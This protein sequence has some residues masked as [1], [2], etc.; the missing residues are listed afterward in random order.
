MSVIDVGRRAM[1]SLAAGVEATRATWRGDQWRLEH[2]DPGSDRW[3]A[4]YV[5]LSRYRTCE[6]YV[7]NTIFTK[8]EKQRGVHMME[9]NG[10][11]PKDTRPIYNPAGR[12]SDLYPALIYGGPLDIANLDGGAIPIE[13]ESEAVKGAIRQIWKWSNMQQAKS[14]YVRT[15]ASKGDSFWQVAVDPVKQKVWLETLPPEFVKEVA[16]DEQGNIKRI[17]IAY[18][19]YDAEARKWVAYE[20]WID[21]EWFQTY[22]EGKPYA[23]HTDAGGNAMEK[24]PNI[25]G[26]VP[27]THAKHRDVGRQF[28]VCCF[29]KAIFKIDE[30]TGLASVTH[31]QVRKSVN[32]VWAIFGAKESNDTKDKSM[33]DRKGK[34]PWVYFPEGTDAK[35]MV[36]NLDFASAL[37]VMDAQR[38]EIEADMPELKL[39]SLHDAGQLSGVAIETLMTPAIGLITESMGNYDAPLV[40]AQEMAMTIGGI[41]GIK[42]FP[43]TLNS[44]D[45][46]D[47]QHN[48]KPRSVIRDR[49]SRKEK[50][51]VIMGAGNSPFARLILK[52]VGLTDKEI[53]EAMAGVQTQQQTAVDQTLARIAGVLG[54]QAEDSAGTP[55]ADGQPAGLSEQGQNRPVPGSVALAG[56]A[57]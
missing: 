14:D 11:L 9:T 15:G 19:R 38:G 5:R 44:Y 56:A 40:R 18:D 20:L 24:W 46:G 21:Q 36:A 45:A 43:F 32:A 47:L 8:L 1:N 22:R 7:D 33:D 51:E 6:H 26:F 2:L 39:H 41:H 49:L 52:E 12:L 53:D 35:P 29:H 16:F 4:Y 10:G 28:G 34:V 3:D 13:T 17:V 48:I 42:G 50:I 37:A 27:V 55:G 31:D 54:G 23:W 30:L 57:A 25:Y